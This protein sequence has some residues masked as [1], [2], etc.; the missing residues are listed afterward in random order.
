MEPN[1]CSWLS[2]LKCERVSPDF[3]CTLCQQIAEKDLQILFCQGRNPKA[4]RSREKLLLWTARKPPQQR[5]IENLDTFETTWAACMLCEVTSYS[6]SSRLSV[7]SS[8]VSVLLFSRLQEESNWSTSSRQ[9]H[10]CCELEHVRYSPFPL[11]TLIWLSGP[12]AHESGSR[13][14][15][16]WSMAVTSIWML[17]DVLGSFV[18][19]SGHRCWK[20]KADLVK[21]AAADVS[22]LWNRHQHWYTA[23]FKKKQINN[24]V[25][26][27]LNTFEWLWIV[28]VKTARPSPFSRLR[29]RLGCGEI[30]LVKLSCLHGLSAS[31]PKFNQLCG[32][33]AMQDFYRADFA[34]LDAGSVKE[35]ACKH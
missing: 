23:A 22:T 27:K 4:W 15:G 29:S 5:A 13:Y 10:H 32:C 28:I 19:T 3:A 33:N 14:R 35:A 12:C 21:N 1:W 9:G 11:T 30:E 16:K 6:I 7:F 18:L 2:W 26:K 31:K 24:K 25:Q 20:P 17:L 8:R 34:K